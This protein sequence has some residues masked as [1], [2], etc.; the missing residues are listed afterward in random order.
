MGQYQDALLLHIMYSLSLDPYHIYWLRYEDILS[1]NKIQYWDYKTFTSKIC[2]LYNDLWS[3]IKIIK[4]YKEYEM[5]EYRK[6]VRV[7]ID[8]T[9][10]K[11]DF[12]I[13]ISP[14]NIYNRFNRRFGNVIDNFNL[15]PNDVI[16]LSK[17]NAQKECKGEFNRS[18][19]P[20][21]SIFFNKTKRYLFLKKLQP[22]M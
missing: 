8:K 9:K 5:V 13:N 21:R 12:I 6:I 1:H 11:G 15:T 7:M 20:K 18:M 3:D 17:L 10:I 2:F 4:T 19:F 14:T 16:Q 22:I